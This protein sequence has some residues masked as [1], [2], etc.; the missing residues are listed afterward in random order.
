LARRAAALASGHVARA[1]AG[2]FGGIPYDFSMEL[3][4]NG[5]FFCSKLVRHGFV[6]ASGGA[7]TL[8]SFP[9]R[10]TMT[11]RDFFERIG[12]SAVDTM[13]PADFEVEPAFDLIAEWRDYRVTSSIR[14]QDLLMSAL[15]DWMDA[16]GYRF[17]EGLG[18]SVMALLGRLTSGGPDVVKEL[19]VR[20]GFPKIPSNMTARTIATIGMLHET[21]QPILERLLALEMQRIEATGRPLHPR[22]VQD[23]LERYRANLG[24]RI[25]Y[26]VV[27]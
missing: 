13:A 22:E 16:H 9:T 5:Q 27:P 11:N 19:L 6:E 12:V 3:A 1:R 18:I 20:L 14:M 4:D 10:L 24:N 23:E 8:P 7:M 17:R 15:F 21:A 26:L 2:L 25:G